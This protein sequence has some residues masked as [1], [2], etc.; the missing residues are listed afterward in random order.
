[1][2]KNISVV[3]T[4]L[5]LVA[6]MPL[7]AACHTTAGVGQDVAATGDAVTSAAKKATP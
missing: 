5:L 4:F 2:R 7:L 3:L 1:M 6:A